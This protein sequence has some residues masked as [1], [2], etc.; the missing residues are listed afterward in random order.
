MDV[1]ARDAGRGQGRDHLIDHG[2]GAAHES[3]VD[4]LGGNQRVEELRALRAVDPAIEELDFLMLAGKDMKQREAIQVPVLQVFQRLEE[5]RGVA[6]AVAVDQG[7]AAPWLARE[8]RPRMRE[9]GCDAAAGGEGD[10][11]PGA[12]R[13][14]GGEETALGRKH[15]DEGPRPQPLDGETREAPARHV[16]DCHAQL[17][18]VE[19]GADGI[20]AAHFLAV[21]DRAQGDE[22]ALAKAIRGRELFRDLECERDGLGRFAPHVGDAQGV[23]MRCGHQ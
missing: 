3:L 11:V 2:I 6:R 18:I 8:Q 13:V 7:E 15:V 23:E 22:L 19:A 14:D 5:H 10:V 4:A 16:L 20:G 17:A 12:F 1:I 9:H 21:E